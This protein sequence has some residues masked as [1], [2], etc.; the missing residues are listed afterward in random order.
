MSEKFSLKDHLFNREKVTYLS[1]QIKT[2]YLEFQNKK[3]IESCVEKFPEL[4]LKQRIDW[5]EQQLEIFLPDDFETSLNIILS[6][7]PPELDLKKSDDDFGDFIFSPFTLYVAK[8]G[9]SKKHLKKSLNALGEITKR[10]SAEDGIRFFINEFPEESFAQMQKWTTS[11][12]Y[13]QR[14]LAT[15]GLRPSLPWN[16]NINFDYKKGIKILDQL[17]S[18]N[19]RYVVRS[20]A[21][22]MNDISKIDAALVL[23]TLKKW[24]LSGNQEKS[25]MDFIIRHSLRTL[26]KQGNKSA[27]AMLGYEKPAAITVKFRNISKNVNLGEKLAFDFMLESHAE[28]KLMIS[29]NFYFLNK[30][31]QFVPKIFQIKKI[32]A[33]KDETLFLSKKQILREMTTKKLYM[34]KHAVEIV[35]NGIAVSDKIYFNLQK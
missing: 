7:L 14:R 20:L 1:Q 25:E 6:A 27:L 9:L 10:F 16:I 29:Y 11:K 5:I 23:N 21:N 31:N 12:N 4:E 8:N 15:E 3:F 17:F 24:E 30:K 22:H 32:N 33:K 19:T 18:D 34:G 2:A 28:Q 35:V 26:I 13:H